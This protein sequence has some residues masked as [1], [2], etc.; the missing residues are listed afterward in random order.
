MSFDRV[1][2][3]WAKFRDCAIRKSASPDELCEMQVAFYS[4]CWSV[5]TELDAMIDPN[6]DYPEVSR[7]RSIPDTGPGFS[8]FAASVLSEKLSQN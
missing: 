3:L 1:E 4:G 7:T 2:A 8:V 5:I 6:H